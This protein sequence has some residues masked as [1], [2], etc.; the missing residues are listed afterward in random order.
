MMK[1]AICNLM[2]V[3]FIVFVVAGC[4]VKQAP[5]IFASYSDVGIKA[6]AEPQIGGAKFQM[7]YHDGSLAV[8]PV[9]VE[10][11][12]GQVTAI[13]SEAIGKDDNGNDSTHKDAY[14]VV[15]QFDAAVNGGGNPAMGGINLG[16]TVATGAAAKVIADGIYY[17][18]AGFP[19]PAEAP[20]EE[21]ADNETEVVEVP[22]K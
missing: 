11:G 20:A 16:K 15:A 17:K 13:G 10:D 18:L 19:P 21:E 3:L 9:A 6:S 14:S 8:V 22:V 12:D 1:E 5:L 7:G 2:I 4:A